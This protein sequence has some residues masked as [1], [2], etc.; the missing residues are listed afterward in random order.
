[1][2]MREKTALCLELVNRA[3]YL[4]GEVFDVHGGR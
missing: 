3:V 2:M 4:W 1:M